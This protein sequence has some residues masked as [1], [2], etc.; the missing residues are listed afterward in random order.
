MVIYLDNIVIYSDSFP[1]HKKHVQEILDQLHQIG[2]YC[3][4]RKTKLFQHQV[5]F[6]G[7]WIL[8]KGV[9]PVD[10]KITQIQSWPFQVSPKGVK[11]LFGM[12]QWMKKFVWSFNIMW[13][14]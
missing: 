5:K 8:A 10:E 4:P 7:H 2:L 1:Q 6:L 11:K 3:S 9:H 14:T 13:V 12:I